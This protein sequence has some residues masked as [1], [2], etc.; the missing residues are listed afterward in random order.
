MTG[1]PALQAADYANYF[2]SEGPRRASR[3]GARRSRRDGRRGGAA[4]GTR[5][6]EDV[7]KTR[8]G[9]PAGY[10]YIYHQKQML[11]D[12][13]RMRA[14]RDAIMFNKKCFEGK[15]KIASAPKK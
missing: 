3:R 13:A 7:E 12:G 11:T 10:A 5:A 4:V 6:R 9:R 8:R 1:S 2:S 14:Y 15:I